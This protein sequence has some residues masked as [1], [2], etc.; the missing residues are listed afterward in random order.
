V[1]AARDA[2]QRNIAVQMGWRRDGDGVEIE[3]EQFADGRHRRAAQ[4]TGH[5]IGLLAIGIGNAYQLGA[6]QTGKH[7]RMIAAHDADADNTHAQGTL[8]V[9]L[10]RLRHL[11]KFPLAG[12]FGPAIP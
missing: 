9:R 2:G 11:L 6:R 4:G 12:Q 10:Y 3:I 1:D 7:A 8:C 5:E